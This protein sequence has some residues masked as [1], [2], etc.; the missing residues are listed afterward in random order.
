[1]KESLLKFSQYLKNCRQENELTQEELVSEL[2]KFDDAFHGLDVSTLSR[3]EREVTHPTIVK[4]LLIVKQFQKY[5]SHIFPCFHNTKE[6]IEESLCRTG[7]IN[8]IGNSKEHILNFPT[9]V[10]KVDNIDIS[11]IRSHEE[12][13]MI[14]KMPQ[15]IIKDLTSNYF[16]I[17]LE[18]LKKWALHPSNLLLLAE[19]DSQFFGMF[20]TLR[21]KEDIFKK[22]INF[23]MQ[24]SEIEELDFA[25]LDEKGCN[26]PF[27]FFAY[28]EKVAS[29]FYL[30]YYAH[31]IANQDVI[32]EVG[33]TPLL[34]GSKKLIEKIHLH[35]NKDLKCGDT[36]LSSYSASLEDILINEDVLKVIFQKEELCC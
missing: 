34:D 21:L 7:I 24:V 35:H 18:H 6:E 26:F 27:A 8:L 23:E 9:N 4:Q 22:I 29:L 36:T 30:R 14:L 15:S 33:S 3:W 1:M 11:H 16:K 13:D 12:I 10:F 31:L 5:S 19:C 28:N 25:S 20:F 17:T 2:Y 32:L